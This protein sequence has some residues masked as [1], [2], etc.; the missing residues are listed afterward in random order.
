M[1]TL[2]S[3]H[4]EKMDNSLK[5]NEKLIYDLVEMSIKEKNK[6]KCP[7]KDKKKNKISSENKIK[8]KDTKKEKNKPYCKKPKKICNDNNSVDIMNNKNIIDNITITH[9]GVICDVCEMNPIKGNRYKCTDCQDYDLCENCYNFKNDIHTPG[10]NF[11][12]QDK[13]HNN[14]ICDICNKSPITGIR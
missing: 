6:S 13:M 4:D 10:H 9:K 14:I 3:I 8:N 7:K 2:L 1:D 11:V 12:N 5:N